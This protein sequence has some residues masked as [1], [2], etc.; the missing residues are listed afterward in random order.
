M[1]LRHDIIQKRKNSRLRLVLKLMLDTHNVILVFLFRESSVSELHGDFSGILYLA[2]M[3]RFCL[4][5]TVHL[6]Y[7]WSFIKYYRK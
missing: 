1:V 5:S 6:S 2:L 7:R 4:H 3:G